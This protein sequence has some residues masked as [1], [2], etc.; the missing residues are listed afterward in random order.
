VSTRG[1]VY[2]NALRRLVLTNLTAVCHWIGVDAAQGAVRIS[3]AFP[4]RTHYADLLVDL[5]PDRLA[6]IEFVTTA[7][8]DLGIRMLEYRARIMSQ[9]SRSLSQHVL[10]LGDGTAPSRVEDG[11]QLRMTM[12]VVHLRDQD[13]WVLLDDVSLAPLAVLGRVG[14]VSERIDVLRATF[15]LLADVQDLDRRSELAEITMVLASI[16]LDEDTIDDIAKEAGMPI[17]LEGT[18]AGRS[19]EARGEARGQVRAAR[20]VLAALLRHRFEGDERVREVASGLAGLPK[21]EA[22]GLAMSAESLDDIL[23]RIG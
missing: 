17:N 5:G 11:R 21:D 14:D 6:H 1:P 2:D 4:G 19:I 13:P 16:R 8:A 12:N 15:R 20:E 9:D 3:E 23:A 18:Q 10:V 22:I 7:T